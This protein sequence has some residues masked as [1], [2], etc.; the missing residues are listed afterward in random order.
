MSGCASRI[1]SAATVEPLEEPTVFR[2][3]SLLRHVTGEEST[4]VLLGPER[5]PYELPPVSFTTFV[6]RPTR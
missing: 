2:L 6:D 3:A 1:S 4:L 5:E